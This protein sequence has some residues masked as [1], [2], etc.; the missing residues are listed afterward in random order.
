MSLGKCYNEELEGPVDILRVLEHLHDLAVEKPRT[1]V[2]P[3]TWGLNK[4]EVAMQIAKVRAS[5]PAELKQ[6]VTVTRESERIVET[7][8]EDATTT[9][10]SARRESDRI[11]SEARA[12]AER[13]I[14]Q[15][16]LQQQ[17]MISESEILKLAKAQA[18]EIRLAADRDALAMRRGAENYAFDTIS[19]LESVVHRVNGALERGKAELQK[20]DVPAPISPRDRMGLR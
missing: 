3:L 16:K 1:I 14:E 19:H 12:E 4:E 6:A 20:T 2:G 15:A 11:V 18:E 5:L 13:I 7:A 8:R 17:T 10:E 9:L